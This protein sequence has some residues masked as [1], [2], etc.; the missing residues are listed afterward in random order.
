MGEPLSLLHKNHSAATGLC[1]SV[2]SGG[3]AEREWRIECSR[4]RDLRSPRRADCS[5]CFKTRVAGFAALLFCV[6]R[7]VATT[8]STHLGLTL[9]VLIESTKPC[10]VLP[11]Q[12]LIPQFLGML[13]RNGMLL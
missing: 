12:A 6:E 1:I 9:F 10:S 4:W 7:C 2:A 8:A 13:Q 5:F 3:I 11:S